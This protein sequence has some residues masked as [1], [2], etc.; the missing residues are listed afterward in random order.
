MKFD[1]KRFEW[2]GTTLVEILVVITVSALLFLALFDGADLVRR[3]TAGLTDRLLSSYRLSDNYRRMDCLLE[4]NDRA[5]L[6]GERLFLYRNGEV[7][8]VLEKRDSVVVRVGEES[9]DTLFRSVERWEFI[10]SKE[11]LSFPDSLRIYLRMGKKILDLPFGI[12]NRRLG[13]ITDKLHEQEKIYEY[14]E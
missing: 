12:G 2:E 8:S 9:T 3:L 1:V 4:A 11:D 13:E 7:Y 6:R 5:E 14:E 10:S